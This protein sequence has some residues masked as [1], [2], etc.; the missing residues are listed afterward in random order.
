MSNTQHTPEQFA[1]LQAELADLKAKY[2]AL[3]AKYEPE[4]VSKYEVGSEEHYDEWRKWQ[5]NY[6]QMQYIFETIEESRSRY[7]K[8]F[9]IE[10]L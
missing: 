3:K 5:S 4:F 2:E 6:N 9:N 10:N 1:A 8:Q 7:R